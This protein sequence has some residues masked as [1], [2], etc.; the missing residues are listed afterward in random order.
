MFRIGCWKGLLPPCSALAG[1]DNFHCNHGIDSRLSRT[2]PGR[3]YQDVAGAV[4]HWI[5][6]VLILVE[7]RGNSWAS[8]ATGI[9]RCSFLPEILPWYKLGSAPSKVNYVLCLLIA[10]CSPGSSDYLPCA[11]ASAYSS[12]TW[13]FA[14]G[15]YYHRTTEEDIFPVDHCEPRG[16]Q[17][18]WCGLHLHSCPTQIE[19]NPL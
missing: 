12:G 9:G 1:A 16:I 3:A 4:A 13:I 7:K 17:P 5:I 8:T 19:H 10:E 18:S 2:G 11:S 6:S 14:H 15:D